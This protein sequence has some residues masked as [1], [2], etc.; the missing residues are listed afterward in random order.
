MNKYIILIAAILLSVNVYLINRNQTIKSELN[1]E[2]SNIEALTTDITRYKSK[3]GESVASV[4]QLNYTI[5][6]LKERE[7][8]LYNEI[9]SLR[10]D[11]KR[12]KSA[13]SV[14]TETK[15]DTIV[16]VVKENN[17][18]VASYSDEFNHIRAEIKGDSAKLS[19]TGTDNIL[20]AVHVIPKKFLFFR[21]GIKDVRTEV[22]N[23][24]DKVHISDIKSVMIR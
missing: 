5:S 4:K 18:F 10:V 2:K 7:S 6:D 22:K 12:L 11:I 15:I 14:V 19:Y 23:S 16:K 17:I 20:I 8:A 1:T 3:L 9:K 21:Y 13:T 24:N